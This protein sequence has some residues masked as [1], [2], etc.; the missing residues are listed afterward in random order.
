MLKL[1]H[2]TGDGITVSGDGMEVELFIE[3]QGCIDCVVLIRPGTTPVKIALSGM[4]GIRTPKLIDGEILTS[5]RTGDH[6]YLGDDGASVKVLSHSDLNTTFSY[7]IP[8]SV[9]ILTDRTARR[10]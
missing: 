8:A 4:K 10:I 5:L 3:E 9:R 2:R 6:I 1:R 7:K